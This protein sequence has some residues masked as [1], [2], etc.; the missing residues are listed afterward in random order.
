MCDSFVVSEVRQFG[1]QKF[2]PFS[3][4]L[5]VT[6]NL[7]NLFVIIFWAI[8]FIEDTI[9]FVTESDT[10]KKMVTVKTGDRIEYF[11]S[12]YRHREETVVTVS[13]KTFISLLIITVGLV[14]RRFT[15][16]TF[17]NIFRIFY[18]SRIIDKDCIGTIPDI[19]AISIRRFNNYIGDDILSI[20]FP[21]PHS[22]L[23][24]S[25]LVHIFF[26][27]VLLIMHTI[28]LMRKVITSVAILAINTIF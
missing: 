5:H 3:C 2:S 20:L 16:I 17:I 28:H 26:F 23:K 21:S 13:S 11:G 14:I 9:R 24:R 15:D 22:L 19:I 12:S 6:N 1:V 27:S 4:S 18:I 8:L 25:N 7:G 10:P